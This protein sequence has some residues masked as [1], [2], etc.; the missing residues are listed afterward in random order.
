MN[1]YNLYWTIGSGETA[2][3]SNQE[4]VTINDTRRIIK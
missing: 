3:G 2:T 4:D 1:I